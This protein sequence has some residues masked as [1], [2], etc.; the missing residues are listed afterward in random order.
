MGY[1]VTRILV[2]ALDLQSLYEELATMPTSVVGVLG[3]STQVYYCTTGTSVA[4][5]KS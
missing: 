4:R 3:F 2:S 5:L 1:A